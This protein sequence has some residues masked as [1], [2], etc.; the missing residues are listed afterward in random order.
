[1]RDASQC[2]AASRGDVVLFSRPNGTATIGICI[3]RTPFYHAL[4]I[5]SVAEGMEIVD[6]W[7]RNEREWFV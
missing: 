1:M 2:V 3:E 7:V 5:G 6:D 4:C